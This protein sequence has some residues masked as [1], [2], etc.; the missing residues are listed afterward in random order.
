[1]KTHDLLLIYIYIYIYIYAM[2]LWWIQINSVDNVNNLNM[3]NPTVWRIRRGIVPG[4][5]ADR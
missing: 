2:N 4:G 5:S 1:L 3:R